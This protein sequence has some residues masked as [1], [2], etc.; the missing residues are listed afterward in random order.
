MG[1]DAIPAS[2][3]MGNPPLPPLGGLDPANL[4]KQGAAEDTFIDGAGNSI[5]PPPIPELAANF[6]QFE[7][8]ELIG[9]AAWARFTRSGRM[10]STGSSS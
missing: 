3:P 4:L 10:T 5:N 2:N 9:K 1:M 6:P 8:L 7:I